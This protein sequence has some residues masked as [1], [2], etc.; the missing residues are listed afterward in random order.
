MRIL[1]AVVTFF[2]GLSMWQPDAGAGRKALR[3]PYGYHRAVPPRSLRRGD[4]VC[5]ERARFF[6]PTGAF[7]GFP[8]WARS[9]FGQ[10]R[11]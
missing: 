8:C 10:P 11:R 9:A 4:A 6:D 1:L 7:R 3:G 5:E 2:S